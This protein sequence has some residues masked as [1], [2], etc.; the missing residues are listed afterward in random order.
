MEE[1]EGVFGGALRLEGTFYCSMPM[2]QRLDVLRGVAHTLL[3][4]CVQA[5][6]PSSRIL[7]MLVCMMSRFVLNLFLSSF[8]SQKRRLFLAYTQVRPIW[9]AQTST[10]LQ[11]YPS[12]PA[13]ASASP[14]P[15]CVLSPAL[16]SV[17][18]RSGFLLLPTRPSS[19]PAD[20]CYLL[21]RCRLVRFGILSSCRP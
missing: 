6:A 12:A 8:S 5:T 18:V 19:P 21:R 3:E 7:M 2:M 13:P 4:V 9:N 15:S 10:H 20:C 11:S 17:I 1:G 16:V 14:Y